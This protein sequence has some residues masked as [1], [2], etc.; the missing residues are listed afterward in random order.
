[1][2]VVINRCF[3]GFSISLEA[4]RFM[5]ARGNKQAI[6]EVAEYN[7][8]L[9]DQ[10]KQHHLERKY[11]VKFYGYGHTGNHGG[12]ERNNVDLVSAVEKLGDAASGELAN[13]CII[14]IPDGVEYEI[15]DYDG[16][17]SIHE[18]HRSWS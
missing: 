9:A 12:Y 16:L 1:M 6:A 7:G 8:K 5:A 18:K 15:D 10:S 17:E 13:L 2:K 3:G 4:A 14:D 11:G